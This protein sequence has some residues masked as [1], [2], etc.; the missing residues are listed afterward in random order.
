MSN[1]ITPTVFY[2]TLNVEGLEIIAMQESF[3]GEALLFRLRC[4]AFG[5]GDTCPE[6]IRRRRQDHRL[7]VPSRPPGLFLHETG[8]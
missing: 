7:I 4:T 1:T 5:Q 6:M 2:R 8:I 3:D